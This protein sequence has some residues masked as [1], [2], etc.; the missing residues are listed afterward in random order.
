MSY[1]CRTIRGCIFDACHTH[2]TQCVWVSARYIYIYIYIH[3]TRI[4][5]CVWREGFGINRIYLYIYICICRQREREKERYRERSR[6]REIEGDG[7]IHIENGSDGERCP[8]HI[9]FSIRP[10]RSHTCFW[11]LTRRCMSKQRPSASWCQ[12]WFSHSSC[13]QVTQLACMRKWRRSCWEG[14]SRA[15]GSLV[16]R[17]IRHNLFFYNLKVCSR[18]TPRTTQ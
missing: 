12:S 14:W 15:P 4:F 7:E 16:T 13:G 8:G 3:N 9:A 5:M 2:I 1:H 18:H 11:M 10:M 17:V 6:E